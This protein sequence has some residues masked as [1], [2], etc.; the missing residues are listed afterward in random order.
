MTTRLPMVLQECGP[1]DIVIILGGTND[2]IEPTQGL[3]NSLFEEI[4]YQG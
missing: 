3:E 4:N 2:I 1:Y